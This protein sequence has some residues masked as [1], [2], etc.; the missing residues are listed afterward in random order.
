[1]NRVI[2]GEQYGRLV[3]IS[4]LPSSGAGKHRLGRWKCSCGVEKDIAISRVKNGYTQSCGCLMV[5][6]GRVANLKHGKRG[7]PEYSSWS[8]MKARCLDPQNKDFPR[9]GGRGIAVCDEWIASF[10]AFYAYM[11]PRPEGTTLDRYPNNN[12][13]Y[14]PGNCRWATASEQQ[15]NR[16]NSSLWHIKNRTF[17]TL[18]EAA[19]HFRVSEHTVWRWVNGQ[20]DKRRNRTT[21]PREDCHVIG[22]Y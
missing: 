21:P 11:G 3:F 7:S 5:E 19:T 15:R 6:S 1:M 14:E 2:A 18:E 13:N 12:G 8:A 20:H 22:K 16:S 17:Q 10:E 9:W 4:L